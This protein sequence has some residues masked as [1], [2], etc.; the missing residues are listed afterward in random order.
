[1]L[2][3]MQQYPSV[4]GSDHCPLILHVNLDHK[5]KPYM[6]GQS[7]EKAEEKSEEMVEKE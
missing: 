2:V 7:E 4:L 5:R 1:M 6:A 3:D